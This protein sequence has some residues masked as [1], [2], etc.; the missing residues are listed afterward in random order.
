M[1][2]AARATSTADRAAM[3]RIVSDA[4]AAGY[5]GLSFGLMY[6]PGELSDP[7][8]LEAL[9]AAVA[10][11]CALLGVHMRA[12]DAAGLVAAVDELLAVA[13][14]TGARLQISHLRSTVDP[15]GAALATALSR[16]RSEERSVGQE[17]VS[18]C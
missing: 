12:Y 4:L 16:I 13:T 8:E 15:D 1:G 2:D 7:G 18:P 3:S 10:D 11:A 17:M 14:A 5:W 6:A 9:A